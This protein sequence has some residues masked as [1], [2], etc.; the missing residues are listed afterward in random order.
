MMESVVETLSKSTDVPLNVSWVDYNVNVLGVAAGIK[1]FNSVLE[2]VQ[3]AS[4][5]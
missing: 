1:T 2:L 3:H 5:S 4:E